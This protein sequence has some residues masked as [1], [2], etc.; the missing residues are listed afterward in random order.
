MTALVS[1]SARAA[2]RRLM[3]ELAGGEVA[4]ASDFGSMQGTMMTVAMVAERAGY[5][6]EAA[7]SKPPRRHYGLPPSASR[8]CARVV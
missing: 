6:S 4:Y 1:S 5:D 7:F 2:A 3:Q 8:G